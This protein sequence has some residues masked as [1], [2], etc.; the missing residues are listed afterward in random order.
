MTTRHS[1]LG[2]SPGGEHLYLL[3]ADWSP[4]K[5]GVSISF[6]SSASGRYRR[7]QGIAYDTITPE[8]T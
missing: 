1:F 3:Q 5:G 4:A 8:N 6:R 2:Y 7:L